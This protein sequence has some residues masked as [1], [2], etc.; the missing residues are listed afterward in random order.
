VSESASPRHRAPGGPVAAELGEVGEEVEQRELP[1]ER[2]S[3]VG[4]EG[5]ASA[6]IS[7]EVVALADGID[8]VAHHQAAEVAKP[9]LGALGGGGSTVVRRQVE[10]GL[11]ARAVDLGG[12][13]AGGLEP[14]QRCPRLDLA[15]GRHEKLA[16]SPGKG[17]R[18]DGL[19]LHA[20]EDQD[21]SAGGDL[22]AD[23]DG[24]GDN[25]RRGRGPDHAAFVPGDPVGDVV[26]L[27]QMHRAVGGQDEAVGAARGGEARGIR[28]ETRQGRLDTV[29]AVRT[30]DGD[31][32]AIRAD[33]QDRDL[34]CRP[35]QFEI[36]RSPDVVLDLGPT[37]PRGLDE[38]GA[39][40]GLGVLVGVDA[41][42]DERDAR[43]GVVDQP[44]LV[45]NS[46]D[47]PGVGA[48]VDD[49]GLGEQVEDEALVGRPA[50]D[51]DGGLLHGPA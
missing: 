22:V 13:L 40:D 2:R 38:P 36:D 3:A 50:F 18:H 21:G 5:V 30:R 9:G 43:P 44:A 46:V 32:E 28:T 42:R 19:H 31:P 45:A 8:V 24:G 47:P 1:G 14:G 35:P 34:V 37:A 29:D 26:D 49:L 48:A 16:H 7:G 41:R 12:P 51:D 10:G 4:G 33:P 27:D 23:R 15:P 17:R 39:L 25:E 20:L 6:Q 11:S